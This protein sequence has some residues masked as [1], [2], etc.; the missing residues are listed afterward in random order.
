ML[1]F[2]S[3]ARAE[4]QTASQ[5]IVGFEGIDPEIIDESEQLIG[6]FG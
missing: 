5:R 2:H 3:S 4:G 6:R 1:A